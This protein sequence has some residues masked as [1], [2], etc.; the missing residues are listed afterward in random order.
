MLSKTDRL[1]LVIIFLTY[2]ENFPSENLDSKNRQPDKA[3]MSLTEKNK[4]INNSENSVDKTEEIHSDINQSDFPENNEKN[5][6]EILEWIGD[7]DN[8][9][10]SMVF[11][12]DSKH[13]FDGEER[14]FYERRDMQRN[15]ELI[16][17][18]SNFIQD[19]SR[20][21]SKAKQEPVYIIYNA[22]SGLMYSHAAENWSDQIINSEDRKL[23]LENL[24]AHPG[25]PKTELPDQS[26]KNEKA[27]LKSSKELALYEVAAKWINSG[28]L[29][30]FVFHTRNFK[31]A[32]FP[33][34]ERTKLI[35]QEN[36]GEFIN[37]KPN[38]VII[39]PSVRVYP[40]SFFYPDGYKF[41]NTGVQAGIQERLK[42]DLSF[43]DY[44]ETTNQ[45]G[46]TLSQYSKEKFGWTDF[47]RF[48]AIY[49]AIYPDERV[50]EYKPQKS[51]FKLF[52]EY[53]YEDTEISGLSLKEVSTHEVINPTTKE[54]EDQFVRAFSHNIYSRG[55][56]GKVDYY[57]LLKNLGNYNH[58]DSYKIDQKRMD[59]ALNLISEK[60][61]EHKDKKI[62]MLNPHTGGDRPFWD[63][64]PQMMGEFA[65]RYTH[66]KDEVVPV[67]YK[68][69]TNK[70][71]M[72][73]S[74]VLKNEIR[75]FAGWNDKLKKQRKLI[76]GTKKSDELLMLDEST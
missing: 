11:F 52:Q 59:Q 13:M 27:T 18:E 21:L 44:H 61:I 75:K 56:W 38:I 8:E 5:K 65:L 72:E 19:F 53:G 50:D 41:I 34:H 2:M 69:K 33:H 74:D 58:Y 26:E 22:R 25:W 55:P 63:N 51:L 39:D 73:Y 36:F 16:A 37:K 10:A 67:S 71:I 30:S 15:I 12:D 40:Q 76:L 23:F 47:N 24:R 42:D 46:L 70:G 68:V 17:A 4:S 62:I 3:H 20:N 57:P 31:F 9:G 45:R 28:K 49:S 7:P 1:K 66:E 60:I 54:S 64:Y 32:S 48:K 29:D 6:L 35:V 14:E 43:M